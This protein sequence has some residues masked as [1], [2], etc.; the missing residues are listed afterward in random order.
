M[1]SVAAAIEDTMVVSLIGEEWSPK[2]PPESAAATKGARG[3]PRVAAAGI[4]DVVLVAGKGHENYQIIGG[5][6]L[7]WDDRAALREAWSAREAS[8]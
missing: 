8:A 6:K 7:T 2:I 5:E 3:R 1:W 4:D